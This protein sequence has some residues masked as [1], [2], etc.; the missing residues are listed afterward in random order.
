MRDVETVVATLK[1]EIE[2]GKLDKYRGDKNEFSWGV[3]RI[4]NPLLQ[5]HVKKHKATQDSLYAE[6]RT[7]PEAQQDNVGSAITH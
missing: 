5:E 4:T 7:F 6:V 3:L 1:S 2:A